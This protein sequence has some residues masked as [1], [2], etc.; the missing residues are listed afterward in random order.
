MAIKILK[1]PT[2]NSESVL[3]ADAMSFLAEL[4]KY[5]EPARQR[6]LAKRVQRQ[7]QYS[8]GNYPDFDTSRTDKSF[9]VA[10]IPSDMIDRTVEITGPVDR[11]M[12]I[13]ALNSGANCFM[14]DFEDSNSPTWE[15]CIDG[16]VNLKDAVNGTISLK[17]EKKGYVLN[18]KIAK[19]MVRPR[20]LH[21]RE[22]HFLIDGDPISASLFDFGLFMFHNSKTLVNRKETPA[23]YIPKLEHG[24]EAAWWSCVIQLSEEYLKIPVGSTRVTVLIETLPA[25]FQMKEI[26]YELKEHIAGLNAGRWDYLFSAIKVMGRQH[27]FPNRS[28][29]TMTT[30]MMKS[31][32]TLL[33]QTCHKHGAQAMGGMAAFIPRKDDDIKNIMALSRVRIDKH[34]EAVMSYD[35]TWVAHPG[36]IPIAREVFENARKKDKKEIQNDQ[37]TRDNLLQVP[38]GDFTYDE[39]FNNVRVSLQYMHSW[40]GGNG[41]V[42]IDHL[43]ED[44]ATFEI[45]RMQVWNWLHHGVELKD[46]EG[47]VDDDIIDIVMDQVLNEYPECESVANAFIELITTEDYEFASLKMYE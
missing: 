15:N 37:I 19:L 26:L 12:V 27:V 25:A 4:H 7:E 5:C 6:L 9:Q 41:C 40:V 22:K 28:Q 11:K 2:P 30:G 38:K 31:Y 24:S 16:Q 20:G 14:A 18:E 36:L 43:M 3:T 13:N 10:P 32:S 44:L 45:S 34:R 8:K 46:G 17:T 39:L 35:G 47:E 1:D 21:L 42:A 33:V 23:F 29:L